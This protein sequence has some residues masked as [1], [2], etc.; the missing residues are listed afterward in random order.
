[1]T[2]RSG[3]P[4]RAA[5]RETGIQFV[6]IPSGTYI[7]GATYQR[8]E[9]AMPGERARHMVRITKPFYLGLYEVTQAQWERV[10]GSNPSLSKGA[11][12]PVEFVSWFDAQIFVN[13]L[14]L[15]EGSGR[16]RLPTEAEWE[17]AA[18]AGGRPQV[19]FFG[20]EPGGLGDYAW[21]EGNSGDRTHPVG[22]KRPNAFGLYDIYGNVAEWVQ[23]RYSVSYYE[24]SPASDPSGPETGDFRIQRGCSWI[25]D[26]W[27][28]RSSSREPTLPRYRFNH[29]GLRIACTAGEA[30][31]P[32]GRAE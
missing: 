27:N 7:M 31:G 4:E 19:Y 1:V 25:G 9:R 5:A 12:L 6:L 29:L 20:N 13:R 11:E 24:T 26:D 10:M 21:Y 32:E 3:A 8:R 28:C 18:R 2:S 22:K 15:L 23:D 17:F 16:Y 14:N 30:G